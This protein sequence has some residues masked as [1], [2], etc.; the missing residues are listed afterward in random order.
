M[1]VQGASISNVI[2]FA[3]ASS[4]PLRLLLSPYLCLRM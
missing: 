1:G 2:T 4:V 3:A